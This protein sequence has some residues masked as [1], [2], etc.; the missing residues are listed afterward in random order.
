MESQRSLEIILNI[1]DRLLGRDVSTCTHSARVPG[2]Y[3]VLEV[4]V[5]CDTAH[6]KGRCQAGVKLRKEL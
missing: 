2:A 6:G 4:P 3:P 1:F 5:T